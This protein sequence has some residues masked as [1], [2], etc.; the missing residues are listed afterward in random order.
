MPFSFDANAAMSMSDKIAFAHEWLPVMYVTIAPLVVVAFSLSCKRGDTG[1]RRTTRRL[2]NSAMRRVMLGAK[3]SVR[4]SRAAAS[5][6]HAAA[7][8][9]LPPLVTLSVALGLMLTL[10]LLEVLVSPEARS[11]ALEVGPVLYVCIAPVVCGLMAIVGPCFERPADEEA[12]RPSRLGRG[13]I[14]WRAM[15]S[16]QRVISIHR[17]MSAKAP[18]KAISLRARCRSMRPLIIITTVIISTGLALFYTG[19][20]LA[21]IKEILPLVYVCATPLVCVLYVSTATCRER[22]AERV[23]R[24]GQRVMRRAARQFE[25]EPESTEGGTRTTLLRPSQTTQSGFEVMDNVMDKR[26]AAPAAETATKASKECVT[27]ASATPSTPP[28]GGARLIAGSA[29]DGN[30]S[31]CSPGVGATECAGASGS[32]GGALKPATPS[33]PTSPPAPHTKGSR[34]N[35]F[36]DKSPNMPSPKAVVANGKAAGAVPT[37]QAQSRDRSPTP[38]SAKSVARASPPR[39]TTKEARNPSPKKVLSPPGG[40]TGSLLETPSF[41]PQWGDTRKS[42]NVKPLKLVER[43]HEGHLVGVP[44]VEVDSR[45]VHKRLGDRKQLVEE[46]KARN[47]EAAKQYARARR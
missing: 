30:G 21:F 22:A 46:M 13:A 40:E 25:P 33:K 31:L 17:I 37:A 42:P 4:A 38:I 29:G 26:A 41:A 8:G 14:R 10:S 6:I 47:D 24:M 2:G 12:G 32:A 44:L 1:S 45:R 16:I 23:M 18:P 19:V 28:R 34:P 43:D 9:S 3:F 7:R 35:P 36:A 15:R 11:L 39:G 20:P 27:T 5:E